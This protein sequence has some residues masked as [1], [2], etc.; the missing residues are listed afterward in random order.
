MGWERE[1]PGGEIAS[2]GANACLGQVRPEYRD[3]LN[4]L[5][6]VR[7]RGSG[8]ELIPL[9]NLVTPS[10]GSGPVQIDRENRT[11]AITLRANLDGKAASD[12]EG[13]EE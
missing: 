4:E 7:V 8:G 10:L 13:D 3:D 5:D 1:H 9:R 2:A 6:L 11:R 12:E